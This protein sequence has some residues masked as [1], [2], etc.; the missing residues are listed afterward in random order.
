MEFT[1]TQE[2]DVLYD[3]KTQ[4]QKIIDNYIQVRKTEANLAS[5]TQI[6]TSDTLNR[7]SRSVVVDRAVIRLD[8]YDFDS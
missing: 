1:Q 3:I 6:V 4:N 8:S 5:S 7:F 2:Q